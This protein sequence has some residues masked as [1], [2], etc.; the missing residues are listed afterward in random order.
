MPDRPVAVM[1]DYLTVVG[2]LLAGET[3]T[4]EGPA[5]RLHDA[6]LGVRGLPRVPVYLGALGPQMLC[7]AGER[8]DGALLNWATTDRIA[9]SRRLLEE[10]ATRAGRD[11]AGLTLTM[12][13]RAC[14]DDDVDAARQALGEQVLSYAMA[15]PGTPLASGYRGLFAEMGFGEVLSE[16]EKRKNSGE[17]VAALVSAVPD[18]FLSSVGYFGSAAGAAEAFGR[19]SQGLDETIVRIVTARPG[20]EPVVATLEAL[21][22]E[23]IRKA[24]EVPG[25]GREP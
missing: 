8:A 15:Q 18:E 20:L 17:A 12:Y 13:I 21:A 5:L 14:V 19:L 24:L 16:L 3:V 9:E 11:P 4:Y 6:S 1:R 25:A 23:R 2:A 22:P 7:L 10:G